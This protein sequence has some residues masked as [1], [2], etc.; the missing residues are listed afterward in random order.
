MISRITVITNPAAQAKMLNLFLLIE[1]I[2]I[3][4]NWVI[5]ENRMPGRSIR[6]G[7][8]VLSKADPYIN[9]MTNPQ[10]K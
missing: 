10:T 3:E 5:L 2:K 9:G 8:I 4:N 7:I 1:T 6:N